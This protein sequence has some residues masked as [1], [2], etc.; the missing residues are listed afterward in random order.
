MSNLYSIEEQNRFFLQTQAVLKSG[1]LKNTAAVLPGLN[2]LEAAA[3][4]ADLTALIDYHEWRYRKLDD[5]LIP[6][7]D[8]DRLVDAL[9]DLETQF[10]SLKSADSP[11]HKVA[12]DFTEWGEKVQHLTPTLSLGKAY[13]VEDLSD[14]DTSVK[15]LADFLPDS[16]VEYCVEPKFDGG[17]I[18]L[19][20]ENNKLTRAATRGDGTIGE[21]ITNN[22]KVIS[23]I[24]HTADFLK[25]GIKKIELRGEAL[26]RKDIFE[27]LNARRAAQGLPLFANPRNAATGGL[28]T[29]DARDT[30]ERKITAFVYQIGFAE[31][32]AGGNVLLKMKNHSDGLD[33]LTEL[34]F[35]VPVAEKKICANIEAV[36]EFCDHW[37]A[38]R[39]TYGYEIDGMVVKVNDLKTQDICG[40]T[41]HHPRWAVAFKFKA[42]QATTQLLNVEFQ[43]GK[44]GTITP[45]AKLDP[46]QLAGVTVSNA[47]LHNEDFIKQRDIRI[48]D[49]VLVERAGDVIPYIVRPI[50]EQRTGAE[51]PIVYPEFCPFDATESVRL[52][53]PEGESAWRCPTCTCGKQSFQKFIYHVSK[54]AMNID[55]LSEAT[56][57][58]F[59][60]EGWVKSLSDFYRLDYDKIAVLK[61]FGK[62][63]ADNLRTAIDR[64]K[65][66]PIHRLLCSLSIP[67]LGQENAKL[68][69]AEIDHIT[70]LKN[71]ETARFSQIKGIGEALAKHVQA[72]FAQEENVLQLLEM[73]SLGVNMRPT[74]EDAKPVVNLDGVFAGKTILFT[75]ALQQFTRDDAEK[76]AAAAGANLVSGVS[77]N[78]N[79]L[80]VGEKAGSKLEKAQKLGTI[81]IM[82]EQQFLDLI[83]N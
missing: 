21:L 27:D 24:P 34:G 52:V 54:N 61:G 41:A 44:I 75:G 28:R 35:N 79:I 45:V 55:G 3:W 25:F 80:V 63:S 37:Q 16:A 4:V 36:I 1:F 77:K 9:R 42:K 13:N 82:T 22:A 57:Q 51:V 50:S 60:E 31:D 32:L 8:F 6:D 38:Q 81:E 67:L 23:G 70:D 76:A 56:I 59:Q 43:V 62:K 30:A 78:L 64:A 10:P 39:D 19:I 20:Y 65:Q 73:E 58:R 72:Y 11:T 26:V 71:W 49:F 74:A 40:Y 2:A 33:I 5:A 17:T 53:R 47:S 29:K 14:F 69:A 18:V 15:K 48:G 83:S 46:V 12:A 66:N 68:I 7:T